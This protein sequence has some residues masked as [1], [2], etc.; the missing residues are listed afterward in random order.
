MDIVV[1]ADEFRVMAARSHP[2]ASATTQ[3][4]LR[5]FEQNDVA[6][7]CSVQPEAPHG[8]QGSGAKLLGLL[9]LGKVSHAFKQKEVC[10]S[11]H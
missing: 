7:G 8:L 10:R 5:T 1:G 2:T 3:N 4:K 9:G 11:L 6:T